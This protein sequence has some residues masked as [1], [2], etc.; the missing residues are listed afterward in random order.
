MARYLLFGLLALLWCCTPAPAQAQDFRTVAVCGTITFPTRLPGAV[1][2]I[3]ADQNGNLCS[4]V[5]VSASI[6]FPTF[7]AAF[8]ATGIAM[9]FSQG[10]NL[11]G[12]T[13]T[14]GNLNVNCAA[15]CAGG[16]FN[17]NADNVA[18]SSTNGQTAAWNYVWDGSAWDRLYGDSTNGAFVNVKTSVLPTGAATA[19]LQGTITTWAGGTLGAMANYGTSPGAVLVPGANVFVTNTNANGQATMANSS[20]V[21]I[22]SNQ[23]N[24]PTNTA[25]VNGVTVLTGTGA[26][27]TGAQRVTVSTDQATNA[28]AALVKGGVGVVNGG[29]R[30]QAVAASQTATVLQ[31]STGATGDYLSHCVIYPASTSPGVVTVFDGSNTA[32]N[33]VILFAGGATSTSNLTPIPVPVGALSRNGSWQVTTGANVSVVCH[34]SFS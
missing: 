24:V 26:T 22:A 15:G 7:G 5:T 32:A 25:Q 31:S 2:Y 33:S 4:S 6:T 10:G 23:S 11:V 19:A 16:T 28:G 13:G 3:T 9:G 1:P 29:S 27:G 30:Y 20:P 12:A 34:G 8:P 14:A 17:N 18:T 21:V